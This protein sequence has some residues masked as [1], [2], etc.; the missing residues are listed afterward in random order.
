MGFEDLGMSLH[1]F[2]ELPLLPSVFRLSFLGESWMK[3]ELDW[4]PKLA[5]DADPLEAGEKHRFS[6]S[7][8]KNLP[9]GGREKVRR[10]KELY[11][12]ADA[13]EHTDSL[14]CPNFPESSRGSAS[15]LVLKAF[16]RFTSCASISGSV[17]SGLM[18]LT[19]HGAS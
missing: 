4:R 13:E 2:L 10:S 6:S 9:S 12:D 7:E 19:M 1:P 15:G 3:T 14:W 18:T 8:V 5:L 17:T 16:P 11:G